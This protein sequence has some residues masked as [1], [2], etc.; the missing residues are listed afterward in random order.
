MTG[1]TN[2]DE[3]IVYHAPM[4]IHLFNLIG[5]I[6]PLEKLDFYTDLCEIHSSVRYETYRK[7]VKK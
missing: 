3:W 5:A 2:V 4:G 7:C 1:N 6:P